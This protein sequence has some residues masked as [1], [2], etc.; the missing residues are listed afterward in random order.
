MNGEARLAAASSSLKAMAPMHGGPN[1]HH[2]AMATPSNNSLP[3]FSLPPYFPGPKESSNNANFQG[4][5]YRY[6][7]KNND[8]QARW[9]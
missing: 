1:H 9:Y 5:F 2:G 6:E 8:Y 3:Q 7:R 4:E